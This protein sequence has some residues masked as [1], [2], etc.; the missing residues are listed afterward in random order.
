[1]AIFQCDLRRKITAHY[2]T[3]YLISF[4]YCYVLTSKILFYLKNSLHFPITL[5]YFIIYKSDM[6]KYFNLLKILFNDNI[7]QKRY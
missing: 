2:R 1:M 7:S 4:T 5:L 3:I 6:V